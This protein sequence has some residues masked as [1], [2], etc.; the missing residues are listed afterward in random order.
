MIKRIPEYS[1]DI[2]YEKLSEIKSKIPADSTAYS[3]IIKKII[4]GTDYN[5][6]ESELYGTGFAVL[7]KKNFLVSN[8][9]PKLIKNE[10]PKGIDLLK[11]GYALETEFCEAFKISDKT[12]LEVING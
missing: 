7:D 12:L 10:L 4:E 11:K 8:D 9:F 3:E 1:G 5:L 2:I 6:A